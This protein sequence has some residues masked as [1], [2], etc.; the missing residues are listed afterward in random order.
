MLERRHKLLELQE[1][2]NSIKMNSDAKQC[3][4][5]GWGPIL[6]DNNCDSLQDHH[7]QVLGLGGT[8]DNSC[9][10]CGVL[11]PHKSQLLS[12]DG[13]LPQSLTADLNDPDGEAIVISAS[14]EC[15]SLSYRL[16][17][18]IKTLQI[19][20]ADLS[21]TKFRL[22]LQN[23]ML[24]ENEFGP[25][26]L[27]RTRSALTESRDKRNQLHPPANDVRMINGTWN[28]SFL[29]EDATLRRGISISRPFSQPC[30]HFNK[31]SGCRNGLRCL[32]IHALPGTDAKLEA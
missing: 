16:A 28:G 5:C 3:P 17:E 12:W 26:F 4:H 30:A 2:A 31:T 15:T 9:R 23:A 32:F 19:N 8:Y 21:D 14:P 24:R 6:L 1:L 7:L 20:F 10:Q 25:D 29:V 27:T 11:T 22:N 13:K 18:I